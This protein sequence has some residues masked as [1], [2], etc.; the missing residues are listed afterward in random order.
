M[1][2][3]VNDDTQTDFLLRQTTTLWA[4][5]CAGP[6]LFAVVAYVLV[7]RNGAYGDPAIAPTLM[8]VAALVAVGTSLVNTFLPRLLLRAPADGAR[9][10][11]AVYRRFLIV[12][13][14]LREGAAMLCVV[15][16][17]LTGQPVA[18]VFG[19]VVW[20][21]ML[22]MKPSEPRFEALRRSFEDDPAE[23]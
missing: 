22:T 7:S 12:S 20:T 8:A 11:A 1:N 19:A 17:L 15:T 16:F 23:G 2:D 13:L 4:A 6:L 3:D 5:L 14:A 18:L 21:A 9:G 10:A